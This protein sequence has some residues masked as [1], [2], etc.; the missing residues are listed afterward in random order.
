MIN[1]YSNVPLYSQLKQMIIDKINDGEYAPDAKIPSEQEL[2]EEYDISRPTVRQAINELTIS[3]SL[4]RLKGKGTFV[5]KD[6]SLIDIK[7]YSGFS[8]SASGLHCR[9]PGL[10]R[11]LSSYNCGKLLCI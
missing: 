9:H 2:C 5:A 7:N 8:D 11:S 1:K 3:G 10:R 4:Y 6:K